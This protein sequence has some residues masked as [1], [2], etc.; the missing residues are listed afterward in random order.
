M[1]AVYNAS[2][3]PNEVCTGEG[4]YCV[5]L[6]RGGFACHQGAVRCV[7]TDT[8]TDTCTTRTVSF[9]SGS[10]LMFPALQSRI[11]FNIQLR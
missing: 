4:A 6:I 3:C 7:E 5:D 10:Y 2:Y 11:R 1:I 8:R 9:V